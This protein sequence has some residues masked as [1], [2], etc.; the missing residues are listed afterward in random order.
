MRARM[1]TQMATLLP[2]MVAAT[3]LLFIQL[4]GELGD[5]HHARSQR[6]LY[7]V[8]V[9]ISIVEFQTSRGSLLRNAFFLLVM[10][11]LLVRA[12]RR[13]R[14]SGSV[15]AIIIVLTWTIVSEAVL[16]SMGGGKANGWRSRSHQQAA[17]S[18]NGALY[19]CVHIRGYHALENWME[20]SPRSDCLDGRAAWGVCESGEFLC[21]DAVSEGKELLPVTLSNKSGAAGTNFCFSQR[22]W[23]SCHSMQETL[24]RFP[25]CLSPAA[26]SGICG[27]GG[28][29]CAWDEMQKDAPTRATKSEQH[30]TKSEPDMNCLPR[31]SHSDQF[32]VHVVVAMRDQSPS[33]KVLEDVLRMGLTNSTVFLYR[34]ADIG[35]DI[36]GSLST[37]PVAGWP[38]GIKVIE[39]A[40]SP[41]RGNEAASYL[42][43]VEEFYE[44]L[45]SM[46]LFIHD[47]GFDSWHSQL[48]PMYKRSRAYYMGVASRYVATQ[49][50][51]PAFEQLLRMPSYPDLLQ[52][53]S[54]VVTLSSCYHWNRSPICAGYTLTEYE[55]STNQSHHDLSDDFL[56]AKMSKIAGSLRS[57]DPPRKKKSDRSLMELEGSA[58]MHA[59]VNDQFVQIHKEYGVAMASGG[60]WSCCA[61]FIA[62][63]RH[64]Q[65]QPRAFYSESLRELLSTHLPSYHTGRWFE[66]NWFTLL[67]ANDVKV[68]KSLYIDIDD[69]YAE[70]L[71]LDRR[72]EDLHG[73]ID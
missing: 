41:N 4:D 43:Y 16:F 23:L 9:Y 56:T 26:A 18:L 37:E 45:P 12:L 28:R 62:Q 67:H 21:L 2:G 34:R 20:R 50:I 24:S 42:S 59:L 5:K 58:K 30:R 33:M 54:N 13:F 7:G 35:L 1:V 73:I 69:V 65:R 39:K 40:L 51:T 27:R 44:K 3:A 10:M 32:S 57:S 38:C 11:S 61:M 15:P 14:S 8:S 49:S 63:P 68:K 22:K 53:S 25:D 46:T 19:K 31:P 36:Q 72:L 55:E 70:L 71:N 48:R 6:S 47:H 17:C 60:F 66:F 29:L 52:F 64:I